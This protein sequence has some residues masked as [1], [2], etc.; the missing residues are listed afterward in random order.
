[1]LKLIQTHSEGSDCTA[2]YDV[3][4]DRPYTVGEFIGEI[5]SRFPNEWGNFNIGNENLSLSIGYAK[6]CTQNENPIPAYILEMKVSEAR[7]S[8]GYSSMDYIV[9]VGSP[10]KKPQTAF[11]CSGFKGQHGNFLAAPNPMWFADTFVWGDGYMIKYN[12]G[13]EIEEVLNG[14]IVDRLIIPLKSGTVRPASQLE[15]YALK[16]AV[17]AKFGI[18]LDEME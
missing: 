18:D 7:A 5:L 15:I 10:E 2:P 8:G 6:G 3:E 4:M 9:K 17:K 16:H 11:D 12:H 1:M 14:K 13:G